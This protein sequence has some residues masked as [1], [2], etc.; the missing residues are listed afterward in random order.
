MM[1][2]QTLP[3]VT[4]D[5]LKSFHA[6]HFPLA[7]APS[8]FFVTQEEEE[9]DVDDDGLGWYPDGVKRH[10]TDEQIHIFRHSELHRL[11]RERE[12]LTESLAEESTEPAPALS[13]TTKP[14]QPLKSVTDSERTVKSEQK[15]KYRKTHWKKKRHQKQQH[16]QASQ[17]GVQHNQNQAQIHQN[18][19]RKWDEYIDDNDSGNPGGLTH[20]RLARELDEQKFESTELLYDD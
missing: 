3:V 11:Q 8:N 2:V 20:R 18:D 6:R 1:D 4:E 17:S 15:Q 14:D 9:V 16:G 13:T 10:L 12:L 7:P 19:K 5:H